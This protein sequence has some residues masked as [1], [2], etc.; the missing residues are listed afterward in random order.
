MVEHHLVL[1]V[2][3]AGINGKQCTSSVVYWQV[4]INGRQPTATH[5][6][7]PTHPQVHQ[8]LH[9]RSDTRTAAPT[10]ILQ[11]FQS[12]AHCWWATCSLMFELGAGVAHFAAALRVGA[13]CMRL[14]VNETFNNLAKLAV[15]KLVPWLHTQT[16]RWINWL[17]D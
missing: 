8:H 9:K 7:D 3:S 6:H 12:Q 15:C 5:R 16:G 1:E 2:P 14:V 11:R 17:A 13:L 4:P 10:R